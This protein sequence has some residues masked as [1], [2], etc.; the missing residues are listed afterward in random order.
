MCLCMYVCM[1]YN[2]SQVSYRLQNRSS[3]RSIKRLKPFILVITYT[4]ILYSR[5]TGNI[6]QLI[7]GTGNIY[8][9]THT[10]GVNINIQ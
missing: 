6:Y 5:G 8:Q 4:E 7:R 2:H 1:C 3:I 9:L 10:V